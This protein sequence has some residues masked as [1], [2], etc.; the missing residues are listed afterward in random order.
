[1]KT[2]QRKSAPQEAAPTPNDS[3][4]DVSYREVPTTPAKAAPV[5]AE[6]F[7]NVGQTRYL[8]QKIASLELSDTAV[9]EMLTRHGIG[10]ID[11][12]VTLAQF[13]ALKKE[14]LSL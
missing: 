12:T 3:A 9:D 6:G 4:E 14:L 13:D 2:P 7:I 11:T 5:A 8:A 10:Q 1:M